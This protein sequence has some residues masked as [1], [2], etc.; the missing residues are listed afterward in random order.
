[1]RRIEYT[2]RH[3]WGTSAWLDFCRGGQEGVVLEA[4]GGGGGIGGE[5]VEEE[6]SEMGE[7]GGGWVG[8][9]RKD[10]WMGHT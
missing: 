7:Q 6:E 3:G 8:G 10:G 9:E 1:M 4:P 2:C 5:V